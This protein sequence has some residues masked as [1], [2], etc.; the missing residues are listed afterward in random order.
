MKEKKEL[1]YKIS[2]EYFNYKHKIGNDQVKLEDDLQLARVE[3]E[4][5]KAQVDKIIESEKADGEYSESLY[6][7]K[8]HQFANRFRKSTKK[9]EEELNIIKVQYA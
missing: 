6:S 1:N 5:L 4:A 8:S 3:N 7:Q 9:N 2:T